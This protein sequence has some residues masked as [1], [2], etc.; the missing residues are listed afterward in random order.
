MDADGHGPHIILHPL[1]SDEIRQRQPG[2]SL[3]VQLLALGQQDGLR[4]VS[5][6]IRPDGDVVMAGRGIGRENADDAAGLVAVLLHG[7]VQQVACVLVQGRGRLRLGR[8]LRPEL[9]AGAVPG[10]VQFPGVE[11]GRPVNMLNQLLNGH[12]I[13]RVVTAAAAADGAVQAADGNRSQ[14]CGHGGKITALRS[15]PAQ[16]PGF[17]QG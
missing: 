4:N 12:V 3:L 5:G 16:F 9:L 6:L 2:L 1:G 14:A 7:L 11:K 17:L 10:T 15:L 13:A 8:V